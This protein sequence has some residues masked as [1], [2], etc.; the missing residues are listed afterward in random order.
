MTNLYK[1]Y[2]SPLTQN[3]VFLPDEFHSIRETYFAE[4][5]RNKE[6]FAL[7]GGVQNMQVPEY[8][9]ILGKPF[10]ST[11]CVGYRFDD[12]VN[13]NNRD[14]IGTLLSD[15]CNENLQPAEFSICPSVST[16]LLATLLTLKQFGVKTIYFE[17][18]A[19]FAAVQQA[20]S[21]GLEVIFLPTR[22]EEE[23]CI[24]TEIVDELERSMKLRNSAIM[25]TNPK[26]GT[27]TNQSKTLIKHLLSIDQ[28]N[29]FV[30]IDEAASHL[31]S[32]APLDEASHHNLIKVRSISK[33][34]GL[35]GL[36]IAF[37]VHSARLRNQFI[38]ILETISGNIDVFSWHCLVK[39]SKTP[40]LLNDM[41]AGAKDFIHNN[42]EL[43]NRY[44]DTS[45]VIIPPITN[46]YIGVVGIEVPAGDRNKEC[47]INYRNNIL[48]KAQQLKSPIILGSSLHFPYT[49][50]IEWIRISYFCSE[51]NIINSAKVIN[52]IANN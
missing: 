41:V 26:Y 37:I 40:A 38:E 32:I 48:H 23:F 31:D 50:E 36:K 22:V 14:L 4:L 15:I 28:E 18:P 17:T 30:I 19:F 29:F 10:N 5:Y 44:S 43:F 11:E 24:H 12:Y 33:N 39:F 49:Y 8:N 27:G 13:I 21:I 2:S 34:I 6:W 51:Q 7:P 42:V 3:I 45:K 1:I 25:L 9:K 35:N 20:N 46:G 52:E 16:G 47:F